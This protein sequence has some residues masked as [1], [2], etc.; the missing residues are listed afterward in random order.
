MLRGAWLATAA[1]VL[2]WLG[3]CAATGP[4]GAEMAA[5]LAAVPSGWK[6]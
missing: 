1:V 3:G 4:K 5:G 2:L 6:A